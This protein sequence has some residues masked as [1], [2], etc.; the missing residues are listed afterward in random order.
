MQKSC[1]SDTD[2]HVW[3]ERYKDK[4]MDTSLF[5]LYDKYNEVHYSHHLI[6]VPLFWQ[7]HL[8]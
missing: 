5:P 1:D 4:E 8:N 6:N 3:Y 2:L 7:N